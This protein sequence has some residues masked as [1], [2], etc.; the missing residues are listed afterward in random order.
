MKKVI[1]IF[2]IAT[3]LVACGGNASTEVA[4]DSTAVVVDSA[5]SNIDTTAVAP[6][7]DTVIAK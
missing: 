4:T 1:A 6:A 2:A 5:V 3:T 7:V